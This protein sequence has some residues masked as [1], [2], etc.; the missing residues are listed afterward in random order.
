MR[1]GDP[2][3]KVIA[4]DW[5]GTLSTL[6]QGAPGVLRTFM[7]Q[8][9]RDAGLDPAAHQEEI[10]I[11]V[12][13]SAGSTAHTQAQKISHLLEFLGGRPFRTCRSR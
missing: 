12:H 9:F 1:A 8:A 11:F 2:L 7:L 3:P 5:D 13:S 6:R 4:I 10:R